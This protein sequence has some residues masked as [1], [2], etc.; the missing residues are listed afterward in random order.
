SV[1]SLL[2]ENG[3]FYLDY[4]EFIKKFAL[5]KVCKS[6]IKA[7]LSAQ[8]ERGMATGLKITHFDSHQH[9]HVLPGMIDIVIALCKKY[10]ID[11]VRVPAENIAWTGG[12]AA[13]L[14]RIIGRLGLTVCSEIAKS[15]LRK[16]E[17]MFP[18]HFFGMLAGGNLNS[19]LVQNIIENLPDGCS[20]IMTHP[21]LYAEVLSNLYPW[22]YHWEEEL[23]AFIA[24]QNIE[25]I[26]SKGI[27]L[28]NFGGLNYAK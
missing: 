6:E 14:G 10:G 1:A 20:E 27:S 8:I 16:A 24:P 4:T 15:K 25:K 12:Y 7:E 11:K 2:D 5:G 23:A 9:L 19:V 18:E 28:I 17:I 13:G 21:G 22:Q 3:N 26:K